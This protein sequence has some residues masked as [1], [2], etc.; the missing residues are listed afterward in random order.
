MEILRFPLSDST[1]LVEVHYAVERSSLRFRDEGIYRVAFA[2]IETAISREDSVLLRSRIEL[3]DTVSSTVQV[4]GGQ[5]LLELRRYRFQPG[6][7]AFRTSLRDEY[8]GLVRLFQDT[9]EVRG[10]LRGQLDC[11]DLILASKL[12]PS[13]EPTSA[14]WRNGLEAVPNASRIFGS[15][16]EELA[17]Y[18]EVYG[19]RLDPQGQACYSMEV[20]LRDEVGRTPV[21][22][23]GS[24][25]RVPGSACAIH[26]RIDL[27]EVERGAYLL[28]LTVRDCTSGDSVQ[29]SRHLFIARPGLTASASGTGT[30]EA[31]ALGWEYVGLGEKQLDS[32]F[33]TVEYIAS[34]DER[35]VFPKLD[36][37]SK[38][39]FLAEFWKRRD[40]DPG[41]PEN[42][43]R[44]DYLRRL[45]YANAHFGYARRPGWRSDRGRILL[46]YGW[47]DHVDRQVGEMIENPY[48][49]WSYEKVQ[50]GVIFV[51]VDRRR[52]N[53]YE[54]VHS[55][56]VGEIKNEN[57]SEFLYH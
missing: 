20:S 38:R 7:Y 44:T 23:V 14:Y 22:Y 2:T 56:A 16:L 26:G 49:I 37:E 39:R 1:S 8:S 9:L 21:H 53:E 6:R 42:E 30:G 45:E 19:L 34:V 25:R 15:G 31:T 57:W 12:T 50:G 35:N 18:A 5:K 43:A 24:P 40:P 11:S 17:F 55:T 4:K 36:V 54:L 51:F 46:Q 27:H 3:R 13:P 29:V 32:L 10:R 52:V 28:R 47:P 33:S 41:T 48:E